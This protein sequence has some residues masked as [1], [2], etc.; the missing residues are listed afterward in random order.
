MYRLNRLRPD[1][2]MPAFMMP[3]ERV[4]AIPDKER[5]RPILQGWAAYHDDSSSSTGRS[6]LIAALACAWLIGPAVAQPN[7]DAKK[8]EAFAKQN[9]SRCHSVG[10]TGASPVETAPAFRTLH[11]RYPVENLE[12][13]LSEGIAVGHSPMPEF[14][15]SASQIRDLI[16]YLRTLERR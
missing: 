4:K 10:H 13:A 5:Y 2:R 8:G 12:E 14:R 3:Y 6:L 7:S 11:K 9:C 1:H 16:S 15:L